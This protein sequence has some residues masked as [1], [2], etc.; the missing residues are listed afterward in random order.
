MTGFEYVVRSID[1]FEE[2]LAGTETEHRI[3]TVAALAKKT[4]YSVHHFTRLFSA[5]TGVSP[6]EYMRSR[7]LTET[8]K[9]IVETDLSLSAIAFHA[10]FAD[11]ETFSRAFK[12]CFAMPPKRLRELKYIPFT[13]TER[14]VP[15]RSKSSLSL[16]K[17]VP[18]PVRE[19]SHCLAGM[20]FFMEESEKSFHKPWAVFMKAESLV[21]NRLE[22]ARYYQYS[23]WSPEE[24]LGGISILCA[25]ETETDSVQEALFSVRTIPASAYLRFVH[26]GPLSEL[27]ETYRYIY[28]DY[29]ASKDIKP[30]DFWEFQRYTNGG[31]DIEILIPVDPSAV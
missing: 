5:V 9:K 4:G 1:L 6:K 2:T 11:Y 22:G 24:N 27:G 3:Q 28:R 26:T 14:L 13:C 30:A 17:N 19:N 18:D 25:V 23:S 8:A 20:S 29:L 31:T 15:R 16:E 21:R 7:I 12:S 10:G